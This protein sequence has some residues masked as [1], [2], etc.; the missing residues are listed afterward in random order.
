[1]SMK[2]SSSCPHTTTST[3]GN[4]HVCGGNAVRVAALAENFKPRRIVF[5]DSGDEEEWLGSLIEKTNGVIELNGEDD[6]ARSR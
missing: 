5:L 1:M 2:G 3:E 6:D 4:D